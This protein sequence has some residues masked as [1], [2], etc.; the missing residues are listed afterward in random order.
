MLTPS[1][2]PLSGQ[3]PPR[4]P[5]TA[6]PIPATGTFA[7]RVRETINRLQLDEARAA[8][9]LGVPVYTLRKWVAGEREP[10][11]AVIRLFDVLGMVEALAPAIHESLLP[12]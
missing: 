8:D 3:K 4:R 5:R 1:P 7:A 6:R 12:K 11:A 9:Y 10:S 2:T